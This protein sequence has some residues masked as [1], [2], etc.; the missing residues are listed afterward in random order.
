MKCQECEKA[1]HRSKVFRG[2]GV[3]TAMGGQTFWDEDDRF[4]R[5][6]PN[7]TTWEYS[8]SNGHRWSETHSHA[9]PVDG[10]EWNTMLEPRR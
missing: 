3:S 8:C 1:G 10:C 6:D 5:H 9:C 2:G 4:H 7:T